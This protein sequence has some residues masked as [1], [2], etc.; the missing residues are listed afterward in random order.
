MRM[1]APALR[2]LLTSLAAAFLLASAPALGASA[3]SR[4]RSGVAATTAAPWFGAAPL[5]QASEAEL[6]AE[7]AF[8]RGLASSWGFVDLA[9][10]VITRLEG[11]NLPSALGEEVSLLKCEVYFAAARSDAKNREKLLKQAIDAYSSFLARSSFTDESKAT[12]EAGLVEAS[13]AY[14]RTLA[15]RLDQ[16]LGDE[17]ALLRD[18]I[19]KV[20][21]AASQRASELVRGYKSIPRDERTD[22]QQRKMY[23]LLLA[24]GE[25]LLEL[26]KAQELGA[27]NF[28]YAEQA[29]ESLSEESIE[30]SPWSMR[31]M[32]GIGDVYAAQRKWDEATAFYEFPVNFSIPIDLASWIESSKEM[33]RDE[34]QA[35]FL[36]VQL[37]TPGLVKSLLAQGDEA[38]Q[39]AAIKW[40]L[41]LYNTWRREG[42]DLVQPQGY[43]ALLDVARTLVD[44]GG[45]IGGNTAAGE[46]KWFRTP[47]EAV[48]QNVP[49]RSQR[50][51]LDFALSLAQT[52]AND[53]KGTNL[54]VRAQ[55]VIGEII[56]RPGVQ[57]DP[58]VLFDAAQGDFNASEFSAAIPAFKRVMLALEG[59]DDAARA[60]LM[61]KLLWHLGRCYARLDRNIEAA[62]TY[63]AA[64]DSWTGDGVW[65]EQNATGFNSAA[66]TLKRQAKGDAQIEAMVRKSEELLA[67][68]SG[69]AANDILFRSAEAAFDAKKY[70]E[71]R[72]KYKNVTAGNNYEKALVALGLCDYREGKFDAAIKAFSDYTTKFVPDA[73]NAT[74]DP[75]K[76]AKRKEARASAEF[77]WGLSLYKLAE[78]GKGDFQAVIAKLG[79][80]HEEFPEQ[81]RFAPAALYQTLMAHVKLGEQAKVRAVLETML[82][83]YPDDQFTGNA[84]KESYVA[85]ETK[86]NAET[87]EAKRTSLLREMAENLQVLNRTSP[88][89]SFP[90]MRR[91]SQHWM[92][93]GEWATAE[94]LLTRIRTQ[95]ATDT[96]V[97]DIMLKGVLPDLGEALA[98]QYKVQEAAEVLIPLNAA[99]A[100]YRPTKST[101]L[102]YARVLAGWVEMT[103][104]PDGKIGSPKEVPGVGGAENFGK[105]VGVLN[106]LGGSAE[107][108]SKDWFQHKFDQIYCVHQWSK[109]DSKQAE[110][111]KR[112]IGFLANPANLGAQFRHEQMPEDLR[113]LFVWLQA[114]IGR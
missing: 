47:E 22:A 65:D 109:L 77:Y 31:A 84:A 81:T 96:S 17:E 85:L 82:T 5:A 105:A 80:Y 89:P 8:A 9:Q 57:V 42:L 113:Q 75:Q 62:V 58:S 28:T 70:D 10:E 68:F 71:A 46:A 61:P 69:G 25:M 11:S 66:S 114:Q 6:R 14:A 100:K 16:A 95:F 53:N 37:G 87:D 49:K 4:V 26:G 112:D 94:E 21:S 20:L 59:A 104:T 18:E 93:L 103:K 50:T 108:W 1:Q 19:Q 27:A 74:T 111:A 102:N 99:D 39:Q 92:E 73:K 79:K 107:S 88:K 63:E 51:A 110:I 60:E 83:K 106:Q 33:S 41:H 23:E 78:Q 64:L 12:A 35:R 90:N 15:G 45:V 48:A 30:G 38:S 67:R 72:Q 55:Q 97:E 32:I 98:R 13:S 3:L 101:A 40:N 54:L 56:S 43:I 76:L 29:F 36:F 24:Q 2:P 44:I 7:I 86:R 34:K 52:V 91:E